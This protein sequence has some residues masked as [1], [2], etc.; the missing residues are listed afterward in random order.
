M[1]S[2]IFAIEK[3]VIKDL[4]DWK[5]KVIKTTKEVINNDNNTEN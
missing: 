4:V 1:K 3:L 2:Y 5:N